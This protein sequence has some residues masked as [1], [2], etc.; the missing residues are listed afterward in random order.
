MLPS[1]VRL[2]IAKLKH[3]GD[4]NIAPQAI[5]NL[6]EVLRKPPLSFDVVISQKEL[7]PR[8]PNLIYYPLIYI[9]GRA[10]LSFDDDDL[11]AL[12]KHLDPGGGT[13][14][15][16][17]ACGS[18][19]FDASFRKF[20]AELLPNNPLVPIPRDDELY[21]NKVGFDLSQTSS[22]PKRPAAPAAFRSSKES[23]S[24]TT[25]RSSTPSSTSAAPW[26]G[27]PASTARATPTRA[28]SRSP[29]TS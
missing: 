27:T 4:W 13:L 2:R 9:H 22:T 26:N 12:R 1:A 14:F 29:P 16:D 17:A 24:T 8:D 20:V 5:P 21:G 23:R 11:E 3:G 25:G 15:A 6:M 19:T 28:P 18:P 7:L 10:A